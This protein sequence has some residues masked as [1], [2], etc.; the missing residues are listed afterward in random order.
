MI[1]LGMSHQTL[2]EIIGLYIGCNITKVQNYRSDNK[3]FTGEKPNC[4]NIAIRTI[5]IY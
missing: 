4:K 5:C 1:T 3:I 2:H